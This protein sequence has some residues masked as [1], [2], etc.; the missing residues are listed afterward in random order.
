MRELSL[1][2][3]DIAQNAIKADAEILR[4]A[5]IEDY[6]RDLLTI[7]VK[8]DGVG[9]D[10]DMLE[11]VVDPF[12]TTRT[13]RKVGL[14]IPLFKLA[15]L[16]CEGD[17]E[18]KSKSGVGTEIIASFKY[19]HI[20]RVPLGNMAETIVTI[21]NVCETMD[22]IYTHEVEGKSFTLNTKEIKKLLEGINITNI[23]VLAWLKTYIE[24]GLEELKMKE[25]IS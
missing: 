5:V 20:D 1:H 18:I 21:I 25:G 8:D 22:L 23:D 24:E 11:K 15:A 19:S 3:L 10:E 12:F 16:Q 14:G 7:K 17:F 4:I 13:T 2:I 6:Q 9:M